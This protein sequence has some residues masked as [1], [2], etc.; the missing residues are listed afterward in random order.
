[1]ASVQLRDLYA[2][3]VALSAAD[4][5]DVTFRKLLAILHGMR[6]SSGVAAGS[7]FQPVLWCLRPPIL[8]K[9]DGTPP[10]KRSVANQIDA[11]SVLRSALQRY[12]SRACGSTPPPPLTEATVVPSKPANASPFDSPAVALLLAILNASSPGTATYPNEPHLPAQYIALP[13]LVCSHTWV[14]PGYS[15][16][17]A[18]A[19]EFAT[20]LAYFVASTAG[21]LNDYFPETQPPVPAS[22]RRSS[23]LPSLADSITTVLQN[24]EHHKLPVKDIKIKISK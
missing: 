4:S 12:L 17:P 7:L 5:D 3:P 13:P 20:A 8:S 2:L 16:Y 11:L 1:M 15:G 9:E 10:D 6:A 18:A 21:W 14:D 24:A 23:D 22:R 19:I